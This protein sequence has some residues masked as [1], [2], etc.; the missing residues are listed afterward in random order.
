MKINQGGGLYVEASILEPRGA[1]FFGVVKGRGD[2][3]RGGGPEFLEGQ[4][5][6][7][8]FFQRRGVISQGG[9]QNFFFCE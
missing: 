7:P 5:G 1:E 9:G 6:G 8:K 4:R 3:L 2:Q